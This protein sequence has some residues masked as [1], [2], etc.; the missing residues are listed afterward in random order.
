MGG[1]VGGFALLAAALFFYLRR[2]RRRNSIYFPPVLPP[3]MRETSDTDFYGNT[4]V[5]P[6][7][8]ELAAPAEDNRRIKYPSNTEPW[9][10]GGRVGGFEQVVET[11]V[12][13]V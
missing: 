3:E 9:E 6:V 4:P 13:K 2:H 1:I 10:V 7:D 11:V 8:E 5:L 12:Q